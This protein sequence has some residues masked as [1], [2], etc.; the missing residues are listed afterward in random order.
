MRVGYH[1]TNLGRVPPA[2]ARTGASLMRET[3]QN[4]GNLAFWRAGAAM[5]QDELILLPWDWNG[6]EGRDDLDMLM[7]PAANH[8]NPE[9][10]LGHLATAIENFAKPVMVFGLGAQAQRESDPVE[11]KSGTVRL[12]HALAAHCTTLFLRGPFTAGICARYGVTNTIAAG[13]PSITLNPDPALGVKIEEKIGQPLRQLSCAGA[14]TKGENQPV[15]QGLF[16]LIAGQEGSSLI[17]QC[18]AELIDLA[19]GDHTVPGHAEALARARD[20]FAPAADPAD[21]ATTFA[22]VAHCFSDADAWVQD[23]RRRDYSYTVNTRIHGTILAMMAEVPSLVV[24]HDARIRELCSVMGIPCLSAAAVAAGLKDIPEMFR[25]LDFD[26]A[27]F[28][29][30]RRGLARLYRDHLVAA[31]LTPSR[32]LAMLCGDA[33]RRP[34]TFAVA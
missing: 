11:L 31:G 3:G 25:R 33:S 23:L 22:R 10:D 26:G 13:C 12:L 19:R 5:I 9:W 1:A 14:A 20:F 21:F 34:R 2:Q 18:P 6:R 28:D 32:N 29:Q 15:E 27:A 17:L 7:I 30:R 8:L 24:G 4:T 16:A